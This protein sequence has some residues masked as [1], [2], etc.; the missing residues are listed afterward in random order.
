MATAA[1]F[2]FQAIPNVPRLL[3]LAE[4]TGL[5]SEIDIAGAVYFLSQISI[6]PTAAPGMAGCRK[7]LFVAM[8]RNAASPVDYFQLPGERTV[9]LGS[10]IE[11]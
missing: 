6:V 4:E 1:R 8:A 11:L 5:E 7:R 2:G 3:E 9:T 10:R